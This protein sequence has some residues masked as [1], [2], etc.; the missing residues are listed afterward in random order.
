MKT[1]IL[2]AAAVLSLGIGSAYAGDGDGNSTPTFFTLIPGE[3]PPIG[4]PVGQPSAQSRAVAEGLFG[5]AAQRMI[6]SH[7]AY[8][9]PFAPAHSATN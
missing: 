7:N 8:T 9:G 3:Q 4:G 5:T 6:A 2:A 1:M